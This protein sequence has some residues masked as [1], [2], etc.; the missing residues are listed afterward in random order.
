MIRVL[1][2]LIVL[3]LWLYG[4]VDCALADRRSVRGGLSKTAWFLISIIPAVGTVLWFALGRP[5]AA[6]PPRPERGQGRRPAAPDDD[7]DF[8][9]GL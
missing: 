2:W 5:R 9:R 1:P 3:V 4:M 7:P 8:L 6:M